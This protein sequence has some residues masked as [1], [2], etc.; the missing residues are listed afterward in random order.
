MVDLILA[1][2]IPRACRQETFLDAK[3]RCCSLYKNR[4][5]R[6]AFHARAWLVLVSFPNPFININPYCQLIN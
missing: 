1:D 2:M 3:E 6:S 4:C 5:T